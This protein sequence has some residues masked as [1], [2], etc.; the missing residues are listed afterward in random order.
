MSLLLLG[1][2]QQ[3]TSIAPVAPLFDSAEVGTVDAS[4][5]VDAFDQD[6]SASNYSDGVTIKVNGSG[7]TISSATRQSNHAI[8]YYVIPVLWHGSGDAVTWEYAKVSG[9]IVAEDDSTPLGDVSA[10][11][12]T[13]NC[14]YAAL[15]DLQADALALSDG[16]PVSTWA[17]Q[18]SAGHNFTQ[19][20]D[21]RPAK[22]TVGGY[23]A[24]VFDGVEDYLIGSD[25]A[26]NPAQ[27]GAMVAYKGVPLVSKADYN[28][29]TQVGWQ[30]EGGTSRDPEFIFADLDGNYVDVYG[31][32]HDPRADFYVTSVVMTGKSADDVSCYANSIIGT[33][34]DSGG[35]IV[36]I[37]TSG[38]SITI[39]ASNVPDNFS[40]GQYRAV[41]LFQLP[42]NATNRA[43]LEARLAARYGVTL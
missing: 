43:A 41:M 38:V 22:Q 23:A 34:K 27:L 10:Q 20:G 2:G 16:D 28:T 15:L 42:P 11:S 40:A 37:S 36:N 5:V 7:V 19:T 14:E 6:I 4:T 29:L 3:T 31:P 33:Y 12:V 9:D 1:A 13:N 8:V 17:D 25:F 35:T 39:G 18:S 32:S 21:A 30:I 26:D 24:V